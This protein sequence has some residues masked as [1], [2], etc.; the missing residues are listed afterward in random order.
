M[1]AG[2]SQSDLYALDIEN[3]VYW[4]Y[5]AYAC[6]SCFVCEEEAPASNGGLFHSL[7][8]SSYFE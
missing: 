1:K 5:K 3:H 4:W 2:G 6:L 7:T 8:E